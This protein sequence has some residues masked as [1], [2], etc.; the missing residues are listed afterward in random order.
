LLSQL[1]WLVLLQHRQQLW[2]LLQHCLVLPP[3]SRLLLGPGAA[4]EHV[5]VAAHRAAL[6]QGVLVALL[7]LLLAVAPRGAS[8]QPTACHSLTPWPCQ[9][10]LHSSSRQLQLQ[11]LLLGVLQATCPSPSLCMACLLLVLWSL[12]GLV[13]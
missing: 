11:Q 1:S 10:L 9:W 13:S 3:I 4:V 5:V 8:L 6:G 7:V 12:V 2:H